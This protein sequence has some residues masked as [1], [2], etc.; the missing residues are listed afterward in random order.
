MD[1]ERELV[2]LDNDFAELP[3]G[4]LDSDVIARPPTTYAKDVW[5]SFRGNKLALAALF[6]MAIMVFLVIFGPMMNK[7]D[8]YSNDYAAL[9]QG[10]SAAH[11]FGTDNLGR[12]LWTRVWIGG[13]VSLLI[14]IVATIIPEFIGWVIGGISGYIGGRVDM[15]IM[16]T[17][18]ILMGIPS[19]IYTILLMVVLGSGNF[20]TLVIAFSITG[21]M[22]SARYVRG[23]V[24]QLKTMDYVM[25][26][27][28]LGGSTMHIVLKRLIP[29]TLNLSVISIAMGIPSIIFAEAFL[30][31]IGL[32]IAPPNPSWGQLIKSAGAVFMQYPY[33]FLAPCLCIAITMLCSNLVGDGLRDAMDPKLRV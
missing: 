18:D 16:R 23:R 25:A 30:S 9:N 10:P 7:Y 19:M 32:G 6:V 31:Y 2:Y 11:W 22:G 24:L 12:D 1:T 13:R 15:V 8:Y 29:N 28:T 14:A 26:S 20:W 4:A 17:I 33:Q 5:R 21:W 3:E 27:K